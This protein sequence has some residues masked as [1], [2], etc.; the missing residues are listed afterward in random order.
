[1][2]KPSSLGK[3]TSLTDPFPRRAVHLD[4][5]T[6]PAAYDVGRDFEAAK[7]AHTLGRARVDYITVFAKCNLGF[8]YYPTKIGVP[9]PGLQRELLGPMLEACH[10]E[11]IRVAVYLNTGLDHEQ[12]LRHR[13][14]CKVNA[15]GQVYEMQSMWHFF[16]KMCLNTAW[17]DLH[18]AMIAEV[19]QDYPV[20]G[21]FLDCFNLA[22]CYGAE[23]LDGMRAEG[24]DRTDPAQATEYAW[25]VT[26]RFCERVKQ[27]VSKLRPG[28][29]VYFNGLPY[30][31]QPTHLELEVLPTGGW[32]Y[33]VLHWSMRYAR[34]LGK[35]WFLMTG[36]FHKS[37]GDLGGLRP[38]AS[39]A[40]DC[41]NALA[42]GGTVSV[43]DHMHPRGPLEPAVYDAVGRVYE[44][45]SALEPWTAGAKPV[46]EIAVLDAELERYPGLPCETDS[47]AGASRMLLE[48]KQQYDVTDG[49]SDFSGYRMLILPD[50]VTVDEALK[51]KLQA[52]LA[53]GGSII[54][55][56][57]SG[58]NPERTAFALDHYGLRYLGP[59]TH[60]PSFFTAKGEAGRG[61]PPMPVTIYSPGAAVEA[62]SGTETLANL[63][64]PY[65]NLASWDGYH[66]NLYCPPEAATGRPAVARRGQVVHFSFPVF[67]A[68]IEHAVPAYRTLLAN[69]LAVLLPEPLVR[70]AGLPSF[71]QVTLTTQ[72]NRRLV[73]LLIYLPEL[74]GPKTQV[75][76]EPLLA[77]DVGVSL[78]LDGFVPRAAYVAPA[79]APLPMTVVGGYARVTVPEVCGHTL[80]VF[81][82][83]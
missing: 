12:A 82:G 62:L 30:S 79:R 28:I 27:L 39:L 53:R 33:E 80:V 74:R 13:E 15:Q 20:D 31:Y 40:Y 11:G 6:M 4:F 43:G 21:L 46:A 26:Q 64:K 83:P 61:I 56:G 71:G 70:T 7:F 37:W 44:R 47:V 45:V 76:E 58:L 66:E 50:H 22:P 25:R 19:L 72:P 51:A 10:G 41:L 3:G 59:E 34:T 55:S 23:C 18:L 32:G 8:A 5:H 75:I 69:C 48:L 2:P 38:E 57:D 60:N 9:H 73:H 65:F 77:R 17:T 63:W 68:Y 14:W 78:R 42:N 67:R 1:M 54:S 36:R 52:H 35:P 16:R 29:F 49:T 81:E 24:L